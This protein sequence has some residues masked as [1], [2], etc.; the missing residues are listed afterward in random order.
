MPPFL[1]NQQ[2]GDTSVE[3]HRLERTAR[4]DTKVKAAL[5]KR[6]HMLEKSIAVRVAQTTVQSFVLFSV[7]FLTIWNIEL[8]SCK[9]D[10]EKLRDEYLLHSDQELRELDARLKVCFLA[11]H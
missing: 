4:Q 8:L 9:Q 10:E 1:C 2:L 11:M 3:K 7:S 6:I 5:S